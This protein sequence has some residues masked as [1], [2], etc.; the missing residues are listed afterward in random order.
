[1]SHMINVKHF[2]AIYIANI[3]NETNFACISNAQ[4]E[5]QQSF[6]YEYAIQ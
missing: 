4:I 1:M 5:L 2:A 3:S 6:A